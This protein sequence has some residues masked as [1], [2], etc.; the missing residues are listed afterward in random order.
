M[1]KPII[2]ASVVCPVAALSQLLACVTND[3]T[4]YWHGWL[5]RSSANKQKRRQKAKAKYKVET[6]AVNQ[7]ITNIITLPTGSTRPSQTESVLTEVASATT[8]DIAQTA[9]MTLA[10]AVR[11]ALRSSPHISSCISTALV[12][13]SISNTAAAAK[14][15]RFSRGNTSMAVS[16]YVAN[17]RHSAHWQPMQQL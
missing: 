8:A 2:A 3:G 14:H 4:C 11:C 7:P 17:T 6:S 16:R 15:E 1:F 5:A 10:H 9:P 12:I 13:Q